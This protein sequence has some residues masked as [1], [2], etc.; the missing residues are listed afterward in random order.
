MYYFSSSGNKLNDTG[1]NAGLRKNLE[2][3]VVGISRG[4]SRLPYDDISNKCG[5]YSNDEDQKHVEVDLYIHPGRFPPIA[6]KLKGETA[7]T[8]PSSGR[9]SVRLKGEL[10]AHSRGW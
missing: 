10:S 1:G 6:V 5:S 7:R 4:W 8:N 3:E 9:Y 2:D